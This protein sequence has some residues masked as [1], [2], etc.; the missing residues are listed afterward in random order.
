MHWNTCYLLY[1]EIC[2]G[3]GGPHFQSAAYA[4][5][6][7]FFMLYRYRRKGTLKYSPSNLQEIRS[8][9]QWNKVLKVNSF[10]F[11]CYAKYMHILPIMFWKS[12]SLKWSYKHIFMPDFSILQRSVFKWPCEQ[13]VSCVMRT[14]ARDLNLFADGVCWYF[15]Y[16]EVHYSTDILNSTFL[17]DV[18]ISNWLLS[19]TNPPHC[20][21]KWPDIKS[22]AKYESV[23]T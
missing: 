9:S 13:D 2:S 18:L 7:F 20:F 19:T 1:T 21:T 12:F 11:S 22:K 14:G 6:Y 5:F 8:L 4:L 3:F 10:E 15:L 23:L 16:H 17:T